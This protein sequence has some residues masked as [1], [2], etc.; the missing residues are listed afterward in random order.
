TRQIGCPMRLCALL[1]A[2]CLSSF[3]SSFELRLHDKA[4][5]LFTEAS[6][7]TVV[8][9]MSAICPVSNSYLERLAL[10]FS[11]YSPAGVQFVFVNPNANETASQ[12]G[13]HAKANRLPFPVYIDPGQKLAVQLGAQ[14]TPEVFILD[15]SGAIRY[16]GR[17]DDALNPARVRSR[18][19]QDAIEAMQTG[20][21]DSVARETKA[22]G[23]TIKR[24]RL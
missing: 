13:E 21:M 16:R 12:V 22:F 11:S 15:R 7:T 17:I 4:V 14:M 1:I 3:A 5:T 23:C 8:V 20:K 6:N 24:A 10:L 9:F 19:L 18:D 2:A